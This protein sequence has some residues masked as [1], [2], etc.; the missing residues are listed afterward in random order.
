RPGGGNRPRRGATPRRPGRTPP[1]A[2]RPGPHRRGRARAAPRSTARRLRPRPGARGTARSPGRGASRRLP[3]LSRRRRPD[4]G[5]AGPL[6]EDARV[7]ER[8]TSLVLAGSA[9]GVLD[10]VAPLEPVAD[11]VQETARIIE[12]AEARPDLG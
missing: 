4:R 2:P 12:L 9:A 10:E 7:V 1:V 6:D 3:N 11:A 8:L 5:V